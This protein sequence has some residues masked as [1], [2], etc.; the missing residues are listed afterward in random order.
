MPFIID[1]RNMGGGSIGSA[2][3]GDTSTGTRN[4]VTLAA[5]WDENKEY[6]K[7]DLAT[8]NGDLYQ[9]Q[10][11]VPAGV[12][13]SDEDY[14]ALVV[15][16][17][18]SKE[19]EQLRKDIGSLAELETESKDNLV[20][21]INEVGSIQPDW[22]QNDE[23]KKDYI[24]NRPGGYIGETAPTLTLN[25]NATKQDGI[26]KLT[27]VKVTTDNF[28]DENSINI[29]ID[30]GYTM[31]HRML[32]QRFIPGYVINEY[33]A[34]IYGNAHLIDASQP[35]TGEDL[36]MYK[37]DFGESAYGIGWHIWA[38]SIPSGDFN[39]F[40]EQKS[41]YTVPFQSKFIPWEAS[42]TATSILYTEQSLTDEQQAQ[43]R[44]NIGAQNLYNGLTPVGYSCTDGTY[45][46]SDTVYLESG[47]I[48]SPTDTVSN[49]V[50]VAFRFINVWNIPTKLDYWKNDIKKYKLLIDNGYLE[51][52]T[53]WYSKPDK[54]FKKQIRFA[55]NSTLG[56]Y[57]VFN[58]NYNYEVI[59]Q[60]V[61][62]VDTDTISTGTDTYLNRKLTRDKNNVLSYS[63]IKLSSDPT[64]P[65][66]IATKQYVDNAITNIPATDLSNCVQTDKENIL[67]D[68]GSIISNSSRGNNLT[69]SN[70]VIE[71]KN[72]NQDTVSLGDAKV[73]FS[74]DNDGSSS[75]KGSGTFT[76]YG[77]KGEE[78]FKFKG[79]NGDVR[80]SGI[81]TPTLSN[82]A[83]NKG[84]VDL[85]IANI[86]IPTVP[87]N[88]SAFTND[89]GYLTA[90]PS[91]YITETELNAKG[92][93]TEHQ[94]LAD[95]ALKSEIPSPYSLPTASATAL[96]GIKVGAG[97]AIADDGTLSMNIASAAVGQIIKVKA[98][99]ASGKPTAWEA[100]DA[101]ELKFTKIYE[102]TVTAEE[103]T[104]VIEYKI[105]KEAV[106]NLGKYNIFVGEIEFA[107]KT[108]FSKWVKLKVNNADVAQICGGVSTDKAVFFSASANR[109]LGRW[110][111]INVY[112]TNKNNGTYMITLPCAYSLVANNALDAE[113]V[114]I[115]S[116]HPDFGLVEGAILRIYAAK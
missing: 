95:Y 23:T 24:K 29:S 86:E 66:Q 108:A 22:N 75:T 26:N 17:D 89:A 85:Q 19:T 40:V 61:Y 28:I 102:H 78:Y 60:L 115:H 111:G 84:Y 34:T 48:I 88:V 18:K 70:G 50:R 98:I 82:D 107:E 113:S 42:P 12:Q 38:T 92:Y 14:W 51:N 103:A 56:D 65:M 80:V 41:T 100:A 27:D 21:A 91:E 13:I 6:L 116:Y 64:E 114:S 16:G 32:T 73:V 55:T 11:S 52:N 57:I 93:L 15:A 72:G 105:T 2:A 31:I 53:I 83:V 97:L 25:I 96:G 77:R 63:A 43:A 59:G 30:N 99:D 68:N 35:D 5:P 49:D 7:G 101:G 81:A 47:N 46:V 71:Q 37:D 74:H 112:D 39:V 9:A 94:S 106:P 20:N 33:G 109:L 62:Y 110:C 1:A 69:I 104:T 67:G 10:K 90:V 76:M 45:S 4:N 58:F 54:K 87:T 3:G 36:A 44:A 8:N 79:T